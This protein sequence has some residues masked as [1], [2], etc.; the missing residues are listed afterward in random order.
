MSLKKSVHWSD[1]REQG[2][3]LGM[4]FLMQVHR[5]FGRWVFRFFLYPVVFFYF[6]NRREARQSIQA[7]VQNI[8]A[9][10]PNISLGALPSLQVFINFSEVMLDKMLAWQKVITKE[11]VTIENQATFDDINSHQKGSILL[12][13]HLG[14]SD[15]CSALAHQMPHLRLTILV[16]T[17]HSEKFNAMMERHSS[18]RQ[19]EFIQVT[20]ITPVS[21]QQLSNRIQA[22]EHI[23][24]AAD[25]T[26]V[27]GSSR[28]SMVD[29]I[30]QKALMP[31]GGFILAGLL[32]CPV[33]YLFCVKRGTY[34]ISMERGPE[35]VFTRRDRSEVLDKCVQHY[36][37]ALER[38]CLEAPLQWF[39]FFDFW[40]SGHD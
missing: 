9:Y 10:K 21:A 25:R 30:G 35:V 39:N 26:P 23:V 20:D 17:Q 6:C 8:Q 40:S 29:F 31:Q 32:K 5:Y 12:I 36:A 33:Y 15:V 37:T 4:L 22:G 11:S 19:I 1:I 13:S 18:A 7:Y 34:H 24:I 3:R 14:N 2:T 27:N 38:R 16:Y 28:A